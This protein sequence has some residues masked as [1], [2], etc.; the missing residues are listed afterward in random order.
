[1]PEYGE[2][3]TR[4]KSPEKYINS[5][6]V[7]AGEIHDQPCFGS[8]LNALETEISKRAGRGFV[9]LDCLPLR[10]FLR[11]NQV[12]S[13]LSNSVQ[14]DSE[15]FFSI[16]HTLPMELQMILCHR[17]VGSNQE[18]ILSQSSELAFQSLALFLRLS[19]NQEP[20]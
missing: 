4:L 6:G 14:N 12:S 2:E 3:Y 20:M 5:S 19:Q 10:R 16:A 11:L 13:F 8:P 18:I 17:A 9:C 7:V 15:R 1:M